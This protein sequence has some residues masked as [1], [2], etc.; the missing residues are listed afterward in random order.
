MK[1]HA[2]Y[3]CNSL[4][5]DSS[6]CFPIRIYFQVLGRHNY[7]FSC[8]SETPSISLQ[9]LLVTALRSG[10]ILLLEN[11]A[12]LQPRVLLK[13][14]QCLQSLGQRLREA[15]EKCERQTPS[16]PSRVSPGYSINVSW[17]ACLCE[18]L[19]HIHMH[20]LFGK[21]TGGKSA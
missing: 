17:C 13:L 20:D 1:S 7:T 11:T 3:T 10:S 18:L 21:V 2:L 12:H 4:S 6:Y 16:V 5:V 8:C 15:F 19:I 14:G 9:R